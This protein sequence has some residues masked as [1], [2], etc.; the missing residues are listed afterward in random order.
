MSV[1]FRQSRKAYKR[2]IYKKAPVFFVGQKILALRRLAGMAFFS[3]LALLMLSN[4]FTTWEILKQIYQQGKNP[5]QLKNEVAKAISSIPAFIQVLPQEFQKTTFAFFDWGQEQWQ[6]FP[7]FAK[8]EVLTDGEAGPSAAAQMSDLPQPTPTPTVDL[9]SLPFTIEIPKLHLQEK[10]IA[11]V[12]A[13]N[14]KAYTAALKEGVAQAAGSAFPG[15]NKMI[16]I[17]GHSTDYS[18]NVARYNAVFYQV[19][20]LVNGD[21]IT[22]HLGEQTFTY[23]V[24]NKDVVKS[25]DVDYVNNKKDDNILLLQTCW[26]PGTSWQRI[27]VTAQP[28]AATEISPTKTPS[29][30][31]S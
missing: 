25:N 4:P 12:D 29:P 5:Q 1:L 30:S 17:F 3:A 31:S 21:R 7:V 11:N 14:A 19:K 2:R 28:V 6:Q 27:F 22:L 18:W 24:T 16:Y 9:A 26:P 10:V 13:D 8:T 20:D 23:Q 15:Q